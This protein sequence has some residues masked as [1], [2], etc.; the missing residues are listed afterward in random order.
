MDKRHPLAQKDHLTLEDISQHR[1]IIHNSGAT[2]DS[3]D[4]WRKR[5][6]SI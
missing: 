6:L 4:E 5:T 2:R 3:I 1:F